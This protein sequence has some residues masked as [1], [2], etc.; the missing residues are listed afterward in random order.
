MALRTTVEVDSQESFG[1]PMAKSFGLHVLLAVLIIGYTFLSGRFHGAEWGNNRAP[2]AIQATLVSSAPSIPLPQDTPPTPNVLATEQ[3]SPAPAPPKPKAEEVPPPEA[4]P[5]PVKAPPKPKPEKKPTPPAPQHAQPQPVQHKAQYGEAPATQIPHSMAADQSSTQP[6]NVAGGGQGFNFPY[7][8]GIIQ[9]KVRESWY[10]P[11]AS[12]A[13]GGSQVHVTF[14]IARD[15]TPSNIR[16]SQ[17]SGIP[18]LDSSALRA[19]QRVDS[20]GPLPR[21]YN[22]SSVSVEYTFTLPSNNQ[23]AAR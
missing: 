21:E 15:G 1:A 5:V 12:T 9:R 14:S 23:P 10:T 13:P 11:E 18:S 16:I 17:S 4:L 22:Q 6:V 19:V 8:V 7:Y 20:F 3:P 2:G